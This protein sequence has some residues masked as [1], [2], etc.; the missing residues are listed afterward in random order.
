MKYINDKNGVTKLRFMS[1]VISEYP[2]G[3]LV[4]F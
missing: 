1:R 2:L 4:R 3:E